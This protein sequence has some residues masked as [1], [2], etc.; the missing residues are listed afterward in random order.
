MVYWFIF[1]SWV[2]VYWFALHWLVSTYCSLAALYW[3][4]STYCSLAAVYWILSTSCSPLLFHNLLPLSYPT[5]I[6]SPLLL[7][8]SI[9]H[10]HTILM[11]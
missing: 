10:I 1:I 6:L 7:P 5:T 3:L 9:P 2:L 11:S 4:H 8:T